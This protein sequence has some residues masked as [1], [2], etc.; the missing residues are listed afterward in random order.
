MAYRLHF[1]SGRLEGGTI[2]QPPEGDQVTQFPFLRVG[3]GNERKPQIAI[4]WE[5]DA[6]GHNSNNACRSSIQLDDAAND[7][8]VFSI[9]PLPETVGEDH[10][11]RRADSFV[12]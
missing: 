8:C 6:L 1:G 11:L 4:E 9:A 7:V 2:G 10:D 5:S 3:S 12:G